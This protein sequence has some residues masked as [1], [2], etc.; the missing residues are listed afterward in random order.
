MADPAPVADEQPRACR[1]RRCQGDAVD[2]LH[3]LPAEEKPRRCSTKSTRRRRP[4]AGRRPTLAR[5]S[6]K[7]GSDRHRRRGTTRSSRCPCRSCRG[8]CAAS[9]PPADYRLGYGP[10]PPPSRCA[11][12]PPR[13]C[14]RRARLHRIPPSGPRLHQGFPAR[15]RRVVRSAARLSSISTCKG[16]WCAPHPH[17]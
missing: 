14:T 6:C 1:R 9:S 8:R 5:R 15:L 2:R 7:R 11:A 16:I 10:A 13:L 3:L 4:Q 12:P 17:V